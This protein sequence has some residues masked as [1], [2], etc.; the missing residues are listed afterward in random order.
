MLFKDFNQLLQNHF[1]KLCRGDDKLFV[2]AYDSEYLWNKY[3][4]NFPAGTNQ[5]YR[6]RREFDCQ[7]CRQFIRNYGGIIA[8]KDNQPVSI[9]DFETGDATYQP[10]V[11][12]LASYLKSTP[13]A[14]IF[15]NPRK[16]LGREFTYETP[17]RGW[18]H[19]Y[20]ELEDVFVKPDKNSIAS[21]KS[22]ARSQY[23]VFCRSITQIT[24]EAIDTV[25]ELIEYNT[26]YRGAEWKQPL[27]TFAQIQQEY[28]NLALDKKQAHYFLWDKSVRVGV[29]ITNLINHSIGV[30]LKDLSKG[31]PLDN[32]LRKYEKVVAP[33]NY[34][35]PKAEFNQRQIANAE[36]TVI[37]LGLIGSLPRRFAKMDDITIND[38]LFADRDSFQ[39]LKGGVFAQ[40]REETNKLET[41]KAVE[42]VAIADFIDEILPHA[43]QLNLLLENKH[44]S[45]LFSLIAPQHKETPSLF[46]W[47]NGFSWAYK[48]NIADSMKE[49]VKKAGGNVN[50]VLRFSLQWNENLDNDNDF[51]AYCYEPDANIIYFQQKNSP[52]SGSLD[53]DI[54]R[55]LKKI[56]V[57]N[58]V[59]TNPKLMPKG[60]YRFGVN[61]YENRGGR[62]GFKAEI[63]FAGQIFEFNYDRELRHKEKV[64]VA[65]IE[66]D[67]NNFKIKKSLPA[68]QT[69]KNIWGID[70]N[71]FVPVSLVLYSPNYWRLEKGTGNK[72]YLFALK[73]CINPE[74]PNGF[75]NEYLKP[76]LLEHKRVF[77]ALG[78]KMNV[79]ASTKQ[80][81][82]LGFSSTQRNAIVARVDN[83]L[84]E[85]LF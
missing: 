8:I 5:I 64:D 84:M 48:G 73:N 24:T 45:N 17:D 56:A 34:K 47:D 79:E 35:R 2:V 20:L 70:F 15:L 23:E 63:E 14:N 10:V 46:R 40:L 54:I 22:L 12:A 75:F 82:G 58:I 76:E 69:T 61:N 43:K 49:L 11:D 38:I 71:K 72:H 85:I 16:R 78:A 50:G 77:E 31:E 21:R 19:L 44:E 66:F 27:T 60:I 59:Y 4:N 74:R 36:E 33:I 65:E 32:A 52:S 37:E 55:P 51:D 25:L 26:L 42:Q 1:E 81:S 68:E 30:L 6:K 53:V 7:C 67:G 41:I 18:H 3:L 57:E 13:I 83:K 28:L 62:S 39:Q 9:W 29:G 80:I